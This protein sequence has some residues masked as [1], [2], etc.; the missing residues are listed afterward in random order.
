M[1]S[2][3]GHIE[4]PQGTILVD[5]KSIEIKGESRPLPTVKELNP[6]FPRKLKKKLKKYHGENYH[7]WLNTPIR[8][9]VDIEN[10]DIYSYH[11]AD[12]EEEL[13][14]LLELEVQN[15]NNQENRPR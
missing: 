6:R 14:K 4:T 12:A 15:E 1:G 5:I 13:T 10:L 2:P 7:N 3:D 9:V 11:S 8:F